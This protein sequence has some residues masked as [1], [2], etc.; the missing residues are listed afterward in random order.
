M[1]R[2]VNTM[3]KNSDRE[4]IMK[5]WKDYTIVD[6]TVTIE[7]AVKAIKPGT[8]NSCGRKLWPDVVHDITGFTTEPVKEIM[9]EFVQ[10]SSVQFSHSVVSDSLPP[11]ESQ[12]AR[13]PCPSPTPRVHSDSRPS[14]P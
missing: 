8:A 4:T 7:K 12:H 11:H 5:V 6:A 3:E 2:I 13:P 1:D 10:F 9:I 14:S